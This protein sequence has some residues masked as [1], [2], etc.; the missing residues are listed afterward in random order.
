MKELIFH[1]HFLPALERNASKVCVIDG[2]YSA[3]FGQHGDRVMRLVSSLGKELGV[4]RSDRFAVMAATCHE[5]LELYHAAYL[6]GGIINPLNLRLAGKELKYIVQ[7]SG[8]EIAFVDKHFASVF[9]EAMRSA[10]SACTIRRTILLGDEDDDVPH[11][12]RYDDLLRCGDVAIPNE[13]E[14]T[15]PVVLMYTGGTTG[16]PK[17]VLI[18]QRAEMLNSYH[19]QML[20]NAFDDEVALVQTPIFHAASMLYVVAVPAAG[21]TLVLMPMFEPLAAMKLIAQHQVTQTAMVPTMVTMM[22][23]HRDFKAELLAS[24]QTLFYGASPMPAAL[25]DRLLKMFPTIDILQGYGMT[26]SSSILTLLGAA[27]HRAGGARMRSV[28]RP[29]PGVR[30]SIQDGDGN[31]LPNGEHGEVCAQGGNYMREYWNKPEATEEAFKGGW[32]HTGDAG[33]LDDGGYLFLTDRVKDMII[34]GAENIY[35]TE[36]ENAIADH[37]SV[38]QVAVIG[39]P[40]DVWGEAVHAI[41]VLLD[42]ASATQEQIIDHARKTI[43]GYKVPKSVE[44]RQD[45]LPLSGAMKVLKRELRAP[46]WEG[47]ASGI[48]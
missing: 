42:G 38:A 2:D 43:A 31:L 28:G 23:N 7:D 37:P 39:I 25:L 18:E 6:G 13:P 40:D 17:G 1:R 47:K 5:Y 45:P 41:V 8:T 32:Y 19:V 3:T 29:V 33:Y 22:L 12:I 9:H 15:D 20:L 46:F 27:E 24:L 44:F 11:D 30:L 35:S 21:G 26:E 4:K 10:G 34:S 36:V 14:E 48:N 16:L